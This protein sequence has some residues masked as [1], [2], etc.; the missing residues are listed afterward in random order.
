MFGDTHKAILTAIFTYSD[1]MDF[2]AE[3]FLLEE[4]LKKFFLTAISLA[5]A[6]LRLKAT[7]TC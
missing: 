3:S 5:A 2:N 4:I 7:E 6:R 1:R